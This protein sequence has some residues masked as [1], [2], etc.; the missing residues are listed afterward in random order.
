[1]KKAIVVFLVAIATFAGKA[2]DPNTFILRDGDIIWQ[3]VYQTEIDSISLVGYLQASGQLKDFTNTPGGL[4]CSI[5]PRQMDYRGAGFRYIQVVAVVLD[6]EMEGTALIQFKGG[7][8]RV[9]V[10]HIRFVSQIPMFADLTMADFIDRKGI[11]KVFYSKN[12]AAV[13]DYELNSIFEMRE[14]EDTW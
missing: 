7:R 12:T 2:Q 14:S 10:N 5:I 4:V 8:Y 6:T 11:Q 3:R 9:T 1:M 13:L